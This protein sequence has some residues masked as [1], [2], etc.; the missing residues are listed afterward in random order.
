MRRRAPSRGQV[1]L[2]HRARFA[3]G[4][5]GQQCPA[6]PISKAAV[7]LALPPEARL[8]R[9]RA[10]ARPTTANLSP[11]GPIHMRCAMRRDAVKL[12]TAA[13]FHGS[14][15]SG[16]RLVTSRSGVRA[17]LGAIF[18]PRLRG[19][20]AARRDAHAARQQRSELDNA[21]DTLGIEPRAS[22]MLS[23]CDTATPCARER[24]PYVGNMG[25]CP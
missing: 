25:A 16:V 7:A 10:R 17:S 14:V 13:R 19:S 9:K 22:R 23:G 1:A 12:I 4:K 8:E 24:Y 15:G 11:R 2:R 6:G 20:K 3:R 5:A 18:N 21:M